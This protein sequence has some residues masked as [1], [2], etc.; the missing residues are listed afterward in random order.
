MHRADAAGLQARFEIEVEIGRVHADEEIGL[1]RQQ[2]LGELVA[3]AGQLAIVAQHLDVAAHRQLVVRPPGL[4]AL[5]GH[6]RPADALRREI[7]P[8]RTQAAEQQA[9]EQIARGLAGHHAETRRGHR[10]RQRTM[11][12]LAS[13]RK[14]SI[15]S[16]SASPS[17]DAPFIA[18]ISAMPAASVRPLR[19]S[20][21]CICLTCAMRSGV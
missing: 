2:P 3:D 21:R 1:G 17:A 8:A 16:T 7:R 14:P 6:L 9:G 12:R 4:E 15:S 11:P 18:P 19:Y 5:R 13:P 10:R 20:V